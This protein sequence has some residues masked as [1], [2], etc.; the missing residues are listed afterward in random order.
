MSTQDEDPVYCV[1]SYGLD[2]EY[3]RD[4]YSNLE[5]A[6]VAYNELVKAIKTS[7]TSISSVYLRRDN[8]QLFYY[9]KFQI[10]RRQEEE[11]LLVNFE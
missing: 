2:V 9:D 6:L 1:S 3:T 7:E 10:A 8:A 4:F 11:L 5:K